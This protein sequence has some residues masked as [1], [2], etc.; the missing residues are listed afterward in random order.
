MMIQT[1]SLTGVLL[2]GV[3]VS[4]MSLYGIAKPGKLIDLVTKFWHK[5]AGMPAAV[6]TRVVLGLCLIFAAA[7]SQFPTT[8]QVLG[9]IALLAAVFIVLVGKARM[10]G[11]IL[12]HCRHYRKTR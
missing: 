6:A 4:L 7:G 3:V 2:F 1:V 10:D 11:L 12:A 9:A 5:P 8:F